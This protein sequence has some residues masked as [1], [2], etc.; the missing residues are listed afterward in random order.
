MAVSVNTLYF[1][2]FVLISYANAG[3][4]QNFF[5]SFSQD[6]NNYEESEQLQEHEHGEPTGGGT[7]SERYG[8]N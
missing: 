6:Y 8:M 5:S 3:L 4:L 1:I 7:G 2:L